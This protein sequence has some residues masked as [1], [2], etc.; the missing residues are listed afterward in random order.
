MLLLGP[1]GG[2]LRRG[3]CSPICLGNFQDS[4]VDPTPDQSNQESPRGETLVWVLTCP[5]VRTAGTLASEVAWGACENT[6][7]GPDPDF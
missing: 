6:A 1:L 3:G 5:W 2:L 7:F 4:P